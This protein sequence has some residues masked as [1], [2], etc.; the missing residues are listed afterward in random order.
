MLGLQRLTAGVRVDL[1]LLTIEGGVPVSSP[2]G[3]GDGGG[4]RFELSS[5]WSGEDRAT[6]L[7]YYELWP[8]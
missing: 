7:W 6:I 3:L 5:L 2:V 4:R 1:L 8:D